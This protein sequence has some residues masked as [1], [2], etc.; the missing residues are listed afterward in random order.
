M[1]FP[2]LIALA[3]A[4]AMDA[5]AVSIAEG[6]RAQTPW[7]THALKVACLFG[8]FQ[9][10]MPAL[11]Y[12]AGKTIYAFIKHID[13]WIA[14]GLLGFIGVRTILGARGAEEYHGANDSRGAAQSHGIAPSPSDRA[15]FKTL[16]VLGL[17]TSID[18]LAAGITLYIQEAN[19]LY[20]AAMIGCVTAAFCYAGVALGGGLGHRLR[21]GSRFQKRAEIASGV[22][23]ILLGLHILFEHLH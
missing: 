14:L 8:A 3:A 18:A 6:I 12:F 16:L 20:S 22:L 1:T 19:I 23:L 4:L 7:R 11:G 15:N 10:G 21:L 2:A 13:H 5:F 17:A 9:A